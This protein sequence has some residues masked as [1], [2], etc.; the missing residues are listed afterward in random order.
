MIA[1]PQAR[2]HLEWRHSSICGNGACV[3]VAQDSDVVRVRDSKNPGEPHLKISHHAWRGF[4]SDVKAGMHNMP[5]ATMG[6][7]SP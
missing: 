5:P 4:I 3:E 2:P 6:D 1:M 7:R